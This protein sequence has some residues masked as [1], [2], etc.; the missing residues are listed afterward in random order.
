MPFVACR[1]RSSRGRERCYWS[2]ARLFGLTIC[3]QR[4]AIALRRFGATDEV[5]TE[6]VSTTNGESFSSGVTAKH[7]TS[8]SPISIKEER[9]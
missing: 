9:E 3:I 7:G 6:F 4:L 5:S 2:L 8:R 1:C